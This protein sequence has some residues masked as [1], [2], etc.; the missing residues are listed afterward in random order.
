MLPGRD[1]AGTFE[2]P[3]QQ[4]EDAGRVAAGGRGLAGRQPDLALGHGDAGEAVHHQ[5]DVV[6]PRRG[7]TP[8]SGWRRRRRAAAR[9]AA[10]RR[11]PRPRRSGPGPPG[12]GRSRGTRAPRGHARRPGRSR[13]P[14]R[15]CRGRSSTAGSTCR[16]REPA[17][18]PSR[19]PA[20]ARDEGVEG[21]HAQGDLLGGCGAGSSGERRRRLSD[22][23]VLDV[24]QRRAAVDGPAE[25]VEHAP[26][27]A[28]PH[29]GPVK[30]PPVP[31]TSV[32]IRSPF[33]SPIGRHTSPARV[34][35]ATSTR[36]GRGL[37]TSSMS[38]TA[39]G[40][41]VTRRCRPSSSVTRPRRT[42]RAA[43]SAAA[44]RAGSK[45]GSRTGSVA[46]SGAPGS[47]VAT[48][49]ATP[50]GPARSRWTPARR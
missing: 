39:A 48:L 35:A 22:G 31:R 42:G 28:G 9:P 33:V 2:Q 21:A 6:G 7:T 43:C 44:T 20:T 49:I 45:A 27:Q 32:P 15:R 40:R 29:A 3:R 18:M 17:M 12:R 13:R 19:W 46:A 50:P 1:G 10:R 36:T 25:P 5:D 47:S 16:R 4:R 37:S 34:L 23:D 11:W 8:R 30:G 38:P 24:G 26:A 14:P 41:P